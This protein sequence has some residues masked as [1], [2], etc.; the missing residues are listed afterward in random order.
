MMTM[1]KTIGIIGLILQIAACSFT[2]FRAFHIWRRLKIMALTGKAN[3][4]GSLAVATMPTALIKQPLDRLWANVT[5]GSALS[6]WHQ[7]LVNDHNDAVALHHVI[8]RNVGR[9]P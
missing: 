8:R 3:L 4:S 2:G 6:P 9:M 1:S 5:E 7:D